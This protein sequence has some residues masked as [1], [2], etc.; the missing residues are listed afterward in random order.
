MYATH[1]ALSP[2]PRKG[3]SC[4]AHR[5]RPGVARD[6]SPQPFETRRED[7]ADY[8]LA[9][10]DEV[11]ARYGDVGELAGLTTLPDACNEAIEWLGLLRAVAWHGGPLAAESVERCIIAGSG[12]TVSLE[13]GGKRGPY[14]APVA[15]VA[16]VEALGEVRFTLSGHGGHNLSVDMGRMAQV[17]VGDTTIVLVEKT[18]PGST[19]LVYEA[20]GCDPRAY[21]IVLAK[22]PEGYRR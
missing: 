1:A 11:V 2:R 14:S 10:G 7:F 21:K 22:S 9:Q 18:G 16:Q 15:A 4:E 6:Q 5:H 20:A 8:G 3:K 17:R 12:T 13:I 19:P